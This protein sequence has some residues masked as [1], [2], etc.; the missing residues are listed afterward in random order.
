MPAEYRAQPVDTLLRELR[1]AGRAPNLDLIG[2]ALDRGPELV[3]GLVQMLKQ[4]SDPAWN[5]DDPRWY[6]PIHAGLLLIELREARALPI[7]ETQ[8]RGADDAEMALEWFVSHLSA[9][10]GAAVPMLLRL[11]GDRH[12]PIATRYTL[13]Q[14]LVAIAYHRPDQRDGIAKALPAVLPPLDDRGRLV[15]P[16]NPPT[17]D[18]I[19]LWTWTLDALARLRVAASMPVG[20]AL[21][22]AGLVDPMVMGDRDDYLRIFKETEPPPDVNYDRGILEVYRGLHAQVARDAE[23]KARAAT[24]PRPPID[25]DRPLAA[26]LASA[27]HRAEQQTVARSQPKVGRN[28][29]CPCGSGKKY[30]KCHGAIA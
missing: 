20:V 1:Q 25:K 10:G 6:A 19:V 12:V 24:M 27:A 21:Y 2:A 17:E 4:P 30:K 5:N 14:P 11:F 18:E 3:P 8:L 16:S 7:F 28:D 15:L 26:M 9:Y 13:T 22:N 23:W 29:P